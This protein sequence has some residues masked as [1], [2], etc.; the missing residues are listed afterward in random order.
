MILR[1]ICCEEFNDLAAVLVDIRDGLSNLP[2]HEKR[3]IKV[4]FGHSYLE[5]I[6]G[7]IDDCFDKRLLA[8]LESERINVVNFKVALKY[9]LS[10]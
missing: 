2:L 1:G 3:E 5:L 7:N 10:E 6:I 9:L 4:N 8:F